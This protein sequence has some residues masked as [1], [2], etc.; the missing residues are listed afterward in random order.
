MPLQRINGAMNKKTILSISFVVIVL[1]GVLCFLLLY[2]DPSLVSVSTDKQEYYT[3]DIVQVTIR[4]HGD[5][6]VDIYCPEFCALG[7][8]P[9][10]V[11]YLSDGEWQ[12]LAGFCPSIEPVL[13]NRTYERGYIRHSLAAKK[14]FNLEL[15]NFETLGHTPDRRLHIVY[16][17]GPFK[18][19][20]YSNEFTF[21]P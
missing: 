7:N 11:E 4:N 1:T 21:K 15:A 2:Q 10:S 14:T 19:P 3:G 20:I 12:Y 17:L 16:Y 18:Q 9:T 13:M 5:R 6:S 8:F